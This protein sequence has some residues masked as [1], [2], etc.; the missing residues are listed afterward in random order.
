MKKLSVTIR[1]EMEVPDDWL[2][3]STSEGTDVLKIG[4]DQYLDLTFEP[5]L[6]SDPEGNWSN[7]AEE[8]FM[9]SLLDMVVS[10]EVTYEIST[11]Q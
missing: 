8:E 9:D 11:V 7:S 1:L 4:A 5:M 6:T 10:E 2:L 3:H